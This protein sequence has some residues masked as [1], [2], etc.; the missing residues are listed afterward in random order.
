MIPVQR[1]QEALSLAFLGAVVGTA[2]WTHDVHVSDF[3]IDATVHYIQKRGDEFL[4][5]GHDLCIQMKST[6][7]A[8]R[9]GLHLVHDL[10]VRAYNHLA[11]TDVGTPRILVLYCMPADDSKWLSI[12]GRASTLRRCGYWKSLRGLSASTNSS[13]QRIKIPTA[14]LFDCT[15][16]NSIMSRIRAG[17]LP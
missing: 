1:R 13:T 7:R 14:N 6:T 17:N 9:N 8:R 4:E 16:L 10:E 5:T 3:G 15:A 12:G 11:D 2:G